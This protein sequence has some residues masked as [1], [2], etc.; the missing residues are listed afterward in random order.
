[1]IDQKQNIEQIELK[2]LINDK[3]IE[4]A[5]STISS[6][7][8][9]DVRDGLKP[10]HRRL[11][12]AMKLLNLSPKNPAKKCARIV[13]DVMGKFHPHGDSAIYETLVRLSQDFS[14]R[15]PLIEGQGNFGNIDGDN[16]AAMRYTEAKLT[17]SALLLMD[18]LDENGS[19]LIPTYDGNDME[20]EVMPGIFPQL[21]ANGTSG[22]AVGMATYLPP[23]NISNIADTLKHRLTHPNSSIEK[24]MTYFKGP[25]FP[26]GGQIVESPAVLS[27]IYKK[28]KGSI[29]IR[30]IWQ[31][32]DLPR[33]QYR[34]V[35]SEIPYQIQKQKLVEEI[36][37]FIEGKKGSV[38]LQD[39]R[40]ESTE[41]LRIVIEP[42]TRGIE[43]EKIMELLYRETSCE[44]KVSLNLNVINSKGSPEVM[45]L[46]GLLDS[47][48]NQRIE[49]KNRVTNFHLE[50]NAKRIEVLEG[51]HIVFINLTRVI[52]IIRYEDDAKLK[53]SK[54]FELNEIQVEAIL[55]MKLRSLRKLDEL[56][57]VKEKEDLH[58]KQTE[59]QKLLDSEETLK[60]SIIEEFQT[61]KKLYGE[62]TELGKRRS[63]FLDPKDIKSYDLEISEP[64]VAITVVI[65]EKGWIRLIK[66]HI[67]DKELHEKFSLRENDKIFY[68]SRCNNL[69]SIIVPS[70]YGNFFTLKLLDLP[71]GTLL[72]GGDN[73]INILLDMPKLKSCSSLNL[74]SANGI[75]ICPP[76]LYNENYSC[77]LTS[78]YG[79][80]FIVPT[81]NLL[82]STRKGKNIFK[83]KEDDFVLTCLPIKTNSIDTSSLISM[84][85]NK[86]ILSF[87]LSQLPQ[88]NRGTGIML[89]K[90]KDKNSR[91]LSVG[92][93]KTG[94]NT[95]G[96]NGKRKVEVITSGYQ[97]DRGHIGK[98]PPE[99][100]TTKTKFQS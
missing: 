13:G 39:I 23:H 85:S 11:L 68:I 67:E 74:S 10:V 35:I 49:V 78:S 3:Y 7:A 15:Y 36:S 75:N 61:L 65:T 12:Y 96:Y 55:N 40:D 88:L 18:G 77:V 37:N 86:F 44:S 97:S 41:E 28:G 43:A 8:L 22:I 93:H 31:K 73:N 64:Q 54:E 50:K 45:N 82:S 81:K 71:L 79:K 66:T 95:F 24:L 98:L 76:F 94:S 29:R 30:S 46:M 53:L 32:E 21:L 57:I 4:Y 92:L 59:L 89:Q 1:M 70:I 47:H 87:S 51:Y 56:A 48:I 58:L 6:R 99:K 60:E 83:L 80:G 26:T 16:A 84:S 34:I 38:W 20:P 63:K 100:F 42:R 19:D 25:D 5:L 17:S 14:T 72:R 52:E 69:D 27:D 90:L 33:G 62:K 91:L 9:P 2:K